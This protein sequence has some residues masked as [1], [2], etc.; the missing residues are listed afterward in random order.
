MEQFIADR[1]VTISA[2]LAHMSGAVSMSGREAETTA[3][4]KLAR[5]NL[6]EQIDD[7]RG[8]ISGLPL[9]IVSLYLDRLEQ[10][11]LDPEFT[12]QA[13]GQG[14]RELTERFIDTL[15]LLSFLFLSPHEADLYSKPLSGWDAVVTAFPSSQFDIEEA[16][17][18]LALNRHT[19]AVFHL[20]R[21]T[22]VGINALCK[23]LRVDASVLPSWDAKLK[24]VD[25]ALGDPSIQTLPAQ[26]RSFF[27]DARANFSAV[28]TAWRNPT[29][30]VEKTYSGEIATDIANSVR[31][32]LRHLASAPATL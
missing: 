30:H 21:V 22:E 12:F 31:A 16:S 11:L 9:E 19:A 32:F 10:S 26:E 24:K 8:D 3:L 27:H 20:M 29:M 28:K 14:C 23:K 5:E 7:I 13:A 18:C 25:T 4:S 17:K 6:K 1:F 2:N 15:S